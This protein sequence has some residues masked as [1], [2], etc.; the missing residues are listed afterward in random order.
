MKA[1]CHPV[2]AASMQKNL[3]SLAGPVAISEPISLGA[4]LTG[5]ER[6]PEEPTRDVAN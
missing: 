3:D 1:D 4:G 6:L 5:R 2:V